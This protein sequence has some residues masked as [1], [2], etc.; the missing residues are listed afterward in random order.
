LNIQYEKNYWVKEEVNFF[1]SL[2]EWMRNFWFRFKCS[3]EEKLCCRFFDG[4][5]W[6]L[7]VSWDDFSIICGFFGRFSL[8]ISVNS[9]KIFCN[10][11]WLADSGFSMESLELYIVGSREDPSFRISSRH[12]NL[13]P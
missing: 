13:G 4:L 12:R 9:K 10:F 8:E 7:M 2:F 5:S 11:D 3:S 1:L 6:T